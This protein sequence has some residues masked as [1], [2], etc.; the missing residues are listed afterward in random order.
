MTDCPQGDDEVLCEFPHCPPMC[1]CL[2]TAMTC[3]KVSSSITIKSVPFQYIYMQE[4]NIQ[5]AI[6]NNM[7]DVVILS[8]YEK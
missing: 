5:P 4:S 1:K 2:M 6:I 3:V 8:M 7:S